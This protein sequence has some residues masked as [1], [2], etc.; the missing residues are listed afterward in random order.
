MPIP[1]LA[2]GL[3]ARSYQP[4]LNSYKESATLVSLKRRDD[5]GSDSSPPSAT[6]PNE[7]F[8]SSF[9]DDSVSSM[10]LSS[11]INKV[12]HGNVNLY[13]GREKVIQK[14]SGDAGWLMAEYLGKAAYVNVALRKWEQNSVNNIVNLIK[15]GLGDDEYSKFE[16]GLTK[17]LEKYLDAFKKESVGILDNTSNILNNVGSDIDNVQK[18]HKSADLILRTCISLLWNLTYLLEKSGA[19]KTLEGQL[20]AVNGSI[21][22]FRTGQRNLHD[23]IMEKL[24]AAPSQ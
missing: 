12:E 13:K 1:N 16:P 7:A 15:S 21:D 22:Y 14:I 23:K 4:V 20:N 11:T 8:S 24:K 10:N 5:S 18:I 19:S 3:E 6:T 2:S 9:S 17:K